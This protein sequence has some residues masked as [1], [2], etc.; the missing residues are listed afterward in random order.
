MALTQVSSIDEHDR[1]SFV[2]ARMDHDRGNLL[3]VY[4]F[5]LRHDLVRELVLLRDAE[6]KERRERRS[7][8]EA[9]DTTVRMLVAD[10]NE[11]PLPPVEEVQ[12]NQQ[13]E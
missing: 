9:K 8:S 12:F 7:R 10:S 13:L 11:N 6:S 1:S 4:H 5:G 3:R 2:L